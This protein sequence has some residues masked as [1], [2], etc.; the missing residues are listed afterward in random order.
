LP[1]PPPVAVAIGEAIG[2][3]QQGASLPRTCYENPAAWGVPPEDYALD[4][5]IDAYV[6]QTAP[7]RGSIVHGPVVY[8]S[9]SVYLADTALFYAS[10]DGKSAPWG[11]FILSLADPNAEAGGYTAVTRI[12]VNRAMMELLI[13]NLGTSFPPFLSLVGVLGGSVDA[14]AQQVWL[15]SLQKAITRV[16]A[17]AIRAQVMAAAVVKIQEFQD[18]QANGYAYGKHW[19]DAM[20]SCV[21]DVQQ[22]VNPGDDCTTADGRAGYL[23]SYATCVST[24]DTC[25]LPDTTTGYVGYDLQCQITK[26]E[27]MGTSSFPWGKL[28]GAVALACAAWVG[29]RT[30][31][32]QPI[33]PAWGRSAVAWTKRKAWG[34][35]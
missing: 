22:A 21:I 3:V 20:K 10:Y 24:G 32:H 11:T 12:S 27:P 25:L 6:T 13:S 9:E 18:C 35:S 26:P 19:D 17:R 16:R 2:A 30:Y 1:L 31:R 7:S 8:T 5:V 34:R 28:L 33:I 15:D 29:W 14:G 23:D 4:A